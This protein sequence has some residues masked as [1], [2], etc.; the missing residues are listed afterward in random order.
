MSLPPGYNTSV[1]T[2]MVCKLKK[3]LYN[4]KQS[5]KAWFDRFRLVMKK[6]YY[7]QSKTDHALFLK[8]KNSKITTLI[9]YVDDMIV[10]GNDIKEM[11]IIK[12]H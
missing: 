10:M 1:Y 7:A 11:T 12:T 8:R 9:I 6:Y 5:L 4:L 2:N 3:A